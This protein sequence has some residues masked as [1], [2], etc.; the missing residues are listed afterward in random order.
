MKKA[1]ENP[2]SPKDG[3]RSENDALPYE[4]AWAKPECEKEQVETV[5]TIPALLESYFESHPKSN[6]SWLA[7]QLGVHRTWVSRIYHG[8]FNPDPEL[9]QKLAAIIDEPVELLLKLAGHLPSNL[10]LA[11]ESQLSD[12]ELV[13]HLHQ[14]GQLEVEDQQILKAFLREEIALRQQR[15][16]NG[17][18]QPV[19]QRPPFARHFSASSSPAQ[20]TESSPA[21]AGDGQKKEGE[22]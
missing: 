21:T 11:A 12:P 7:D 9:C 22:A 14:I 4:A 6:V 20:F 5:Q 16:N 2:S 18:A 13:W 10:S 19:D 3:G 15:R 1:K 17:Q 8:K